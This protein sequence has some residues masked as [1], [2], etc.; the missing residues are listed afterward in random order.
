MV[1]SEVSSRFAQGLCCKATSWHIHVT[2]GEFNVAAN[3]ADCF[4]TEDRPRRW[5]HPGGNVTGVTNNLRPHHAL[6][7]K[8]K[9]FAGWGEQG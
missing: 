3:L 1:L 9:V 7:A 2:G 5:I 6:H 4:Q 8:H